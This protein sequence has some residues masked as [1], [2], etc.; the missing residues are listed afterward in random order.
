MQSA[1]PLHNSSLRVQDPDDSAMT[2]MKS[3][4]ADKD[5][6]LKGNFRYGDSRE[7]ANRIVRSP[8]WF[9]NG[10]LEDPPDEAKDAASSAPA[11][12]HT[13]QWRDQ[14]RG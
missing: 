11:I 14:S 2:A 10:D 8:V 4:G 6:V 5:A 7:C 9:G 3:L 1:A 12:G 13:V